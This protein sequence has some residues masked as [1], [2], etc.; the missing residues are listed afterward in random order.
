M[1]LNCFSL[2]TSCNSR[3]GGR[4]QPTP[5]DRLAWGP[6]R[7]RISP[8]MK[9]S[10]SLRWFIPEKIRLT[11]SLMTVT[12]FFRHF[13]DEYAD[14]APA[15]QN[16]RE[17]QTLGRT[18]HCPK[19]RKL[20]DDRPFTGGS[21]RISWQFPTYPLSGQPDTGCSPKMFHEKAVCH[22]GSISLNLAL[23]SVSPEGKRM[24]TVIPL[25]FP[26]TGEVI[27]ISARS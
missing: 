22:T 6:W 23:V 27:T 17:I 2:A 7:L 21:R 1:P 18:V 25:V 3:S 26:G 13:L 9:L 4:R 14:V 12:S 20:A 8:E 10:V 24:E 11:D 16:T 19:I 5:S 15:P